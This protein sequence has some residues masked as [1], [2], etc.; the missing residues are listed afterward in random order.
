VVKP[1]I[2]LSI[3]STCSKLA[4]ERPLTL[5]AKLTTP[6]QQLLLQSSDCQVKH[7]S[8]T[9]KQQNIRLAFDSKLGK[10]ISN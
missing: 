5:A 4:A 9:A 3:T 2:R 6:L 10:H 1:C 8:L 7:G